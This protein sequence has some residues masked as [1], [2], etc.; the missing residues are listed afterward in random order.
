MSHTVLLKKTRNASPINLSGRSV[1]AGYDVYVD[2]VKVGS[3]EGRSPGCGSSRPFHELRDHAGQPVS[4][5]V[6]VRGRDREKLNAL[7]IAL[8][9]AFPRAPIC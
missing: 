4:G 2:G 5:V 9:N 6:G 8:F 7:A 1:P 3:L